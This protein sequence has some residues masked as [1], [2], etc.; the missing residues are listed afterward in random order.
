MEISEPCIGYKPNKMTQMESAI[1]GK[2][3]KQSLITSAVVSLP[4]ILIFSKD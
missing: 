3:I 4:E 1:L 2:T